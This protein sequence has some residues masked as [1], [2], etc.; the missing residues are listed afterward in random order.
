MRIDFQWGAT[1]GAR[2]EQGPGPLPSRWLSPG[3]A[4]V[5]RVLVM[6]TEPSG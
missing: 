4:Y 2:V 1:V 3:V 5:S 6:I